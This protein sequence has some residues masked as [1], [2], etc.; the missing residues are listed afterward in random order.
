MHN[1]KQLLNTTLMILLLPACGSKHHDAYELLERP[2]QL[3]INPN[4]Q[5]PKIIDETLVTNG[6]GD[7]VNLS[8]SQYAPILTLSMNFETS[9]EILEQ[10]MKH[11]NFMLTDRNR[12]DGIF[13]VTF[14]TDAYQASNEKETKKDEPLEGTYDA[15][16]VYSSDHGLMG[17]LTGSLF[18]SKTSFRK[19]QLTVKQVGNNTLVIAKDI[20]AVT[21]QKNISDNTD[22]V[23]DASISGPD[24]S[25]RRLL[26]T[27]YKYLHDGFSEREKH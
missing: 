5:T 24:D 26:S 23:V 12:S 16:G 6:L 14:D 11:K 1:I 9:W 15:D 20:G 27:L 22:E 10:V 2:P 7:R 19:Y 4:I 13:L 25:Q 3:A 8:G 18:S 21:T 17:L